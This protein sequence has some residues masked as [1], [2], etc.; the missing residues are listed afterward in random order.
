MAHSFS[1]FQVVTITDEAS[2]YVGRKAA[3]ETLTDWDGVYTVRVYSRCGIFLSDVYATCHER[4]LR[5]WEP[6]AA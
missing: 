2:A 6:A 4:N 5:A 3:I 1:Q